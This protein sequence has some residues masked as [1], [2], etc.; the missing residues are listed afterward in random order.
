MILKLPAEQSIAI[1]TDFSCSVN[2]QAQNGDLYGIYLVSGR[3]TVFQQ[4]PRTI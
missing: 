3:V 2:F 1:V 4:L